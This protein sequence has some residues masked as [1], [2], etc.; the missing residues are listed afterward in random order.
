MDSG[1]GGGS[2]ISRLLSISYIVYNNSC[3][4]IDT[5][6]VCNTKETRLDLNYCLLKCNIKHISS[7][8]TCTFDNICLVRWWSYPRFAGRRE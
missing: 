4:Q 8:L 6:L 1:G 7:S 5:F 2:Q 3:T